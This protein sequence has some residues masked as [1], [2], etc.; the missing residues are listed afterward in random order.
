MAASCRVWA[1]AGR[2]ARIPVAR[3]CDR[4][5]DARVDEGLGFG[6]A[7]WRAADASA[8]AERTLLKSNRVGKW[9]RRKG[10]GPQTNRQRVESIAVRSRRAHGGPVQRVLRCVP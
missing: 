9:T 10:S 2:A 6:H 1:S 3:S 5:L 4:K 8:R 7:T